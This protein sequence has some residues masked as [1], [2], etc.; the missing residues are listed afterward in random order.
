MA[1]RRPGYWK[2]FYERNRERRIAESVAYQREHAEERREYMARYRREHPE[3]WERTEEQRAER[4]RRRRERYASDA[5][6][7]R[8][9][10]DAAADYRRRNPDQRLARRLRAYGLTL[11]EY[12]E[13]AE[14]GCAI[15]RRPVDPVGGK[16]LRLD[17]CHATGQFRGF[18]CDECNLGLGKFRDDPELLE[19]AALYLRSR[20]RDPAADQ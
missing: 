12:R 10:I 15:C 5:E 1:K 17:H 9:H 19:R 8:K 11:D 13:H 4:N 14:R 20:E 18:L 16:R 3:K 2:E 6:F 7:R